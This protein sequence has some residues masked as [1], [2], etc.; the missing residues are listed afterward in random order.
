MPGYLVEWEIRDRLVAVIGL[1]PVGLRRLVGLLEAGAIVRAVDPEAD[2][3]LADRKLVGPE[4][5]QTAPDSLRIHVVNNHYEDSCLDGCVMVVAATGTPVDRV[6]ADDA[7]RRGIPVNVVGDPD[8]GDLRIPA[9]WSRG[10]LTL[11]VSTSGAGPGLAAALRDRAVGALGETAV[12]WVELVG[13]LRPKVLDQLGSDHGR[14]LLREWAD[15]AWLDRID[16]EGIEA[17]SQRF[18]EMLKSRSP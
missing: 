16:A 6:I 5:S 9:T 7:A 11:A 18:Q 17:V 2:R 12:A 1:G 14:A 13:R 8:R 3:R 15:P 10:P 4:I